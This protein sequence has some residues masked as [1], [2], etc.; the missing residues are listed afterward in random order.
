MVFCAD[1]ASAAASLV[2]ARDRA[3]AEVVAEQKRTAAAERRTDEQRQASLNSEALSA[4]A[5]E[6]ASKQLAAVEAVRQVEAAAT[7]EARMRQQEL[8]VQ[9]TASEKTIGQARSEASS[10]RADVAA[11]S[12]RAE[13]AVGAET[14][15]KTLR[16]TVSQQQQSLR[17]A[18]GQIDT[19]RMSIRYS[20]PPGPPIV[21]ASLGATPAATPSVPL[22]STGGHHV[23][24]RVRTSPGQALLAGA[25]EH[26]L[27]PRYSV[28]S[29]VEALA[30]AAAARVAAAS[31]SISSSPQTPAS[32]A[33]G[34]V[35]NDLHRGGFAQIY[36]GTGAWRTPNQWRGV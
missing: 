1:T 18:E 25:V 8:Q 20:S 22:A 2:D 24:N 10:A 3:M 15:L 4:Q 12:A 29:K 21:E 31:S 35:T 30:L 13:A 19:L 9:L 14:E 23:I 17:K 26:L 11:L 27:S 5:I 28:E 6:E 33:A 16:D 32:Q 36:G 34:S 7:A